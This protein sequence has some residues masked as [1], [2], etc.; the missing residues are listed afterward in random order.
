[1]NASA[2]HP[3]QLASRLE[4]NGYIIIENALSADRLR[5]LNDAVDRYLA[6]YPEEWIQMNECT[7]EIENVLR[8]TDEFVVLVH[9][10]LNDT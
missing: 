6:A 8:K 5:T 7:I 1:M 4:V 9:G 10:F 3:V 2:S